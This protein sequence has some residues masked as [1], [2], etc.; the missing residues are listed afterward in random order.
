MAVDVFKDDSNL[1]EVNMSGMPLNNVEL[2]KIAAWNKLKITKL[3]IS[4]NNLNF[5]PTNGNGD[6]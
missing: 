1:V 6:V 5:R 4:S 2:P 3:T